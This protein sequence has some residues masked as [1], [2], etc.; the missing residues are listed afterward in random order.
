MVCPHCKVAFHEK[1][2]KQFL[3]TVQ[4]SGDWY[5]HATVCPECEPVTIS[6]SASGNVQVDFPPMR[7]TAY[8]KGA[9]RPVPAQ[10][11]E[12]YASDF[13]EACTVL[14]DSEK[15]SAALSRRC[16]QA[17]LRDKAGCKKKDL[18]DQ[19]DE[20]IDCARRPG[21]TGLL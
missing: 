13:Q 14:P 11:T 10:V 21:G 16:L 6:L 5:A 2:N 8:P 18:A 15:A 3:F 9:A 17:I 12:P 19:I 1:W 7:W 20:V 4:T